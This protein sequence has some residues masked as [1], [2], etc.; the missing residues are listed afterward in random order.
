MFKRS[1]AFPLKI[2]G[3]NNSSLLCPPERKAHPPSQADVLPRQRRP[4]LQTRR[5]QSQRP[6]AH[7]DI[8]SFVCRSIE[9]EGPILDVETD[10]EIAGGLPAKLWVYPAS[11]LVRMPI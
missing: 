6:F 8:H 9:L 7:P 2:M 5:L 1:T 10:G 4:R 11:L 3:T